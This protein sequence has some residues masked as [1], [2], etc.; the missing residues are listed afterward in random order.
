MMLGM[1]RLLPWTRSDLR[2]KRH[3][4]QLRKRL[5]FHLTEHSYALTVQPGWKPDAGRNRNTFCTRDTC[6]VL[7]AQGTGKIF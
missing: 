2:S 1:H 3:Y 4:L 6:K 5:N 7:S